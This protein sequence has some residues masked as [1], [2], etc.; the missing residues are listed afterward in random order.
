MQSDEKAV[1]HGA[2][3]KIASRCNL[4]CKYCYVYNM[5]D[6]TWVSRPAVMEPE[7]IAAMLDKVSAHCID[8]EVPHFEFILHGGEPLLA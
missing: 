3:V 6:R 7:T 5:G 8:H 1:C 4:N 2:I